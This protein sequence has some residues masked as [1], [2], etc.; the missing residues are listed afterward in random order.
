MWARAT[1]SASSRRSAT[2]SSTS[3]IAGPGQP[4]P[5]L[6]HP[7][8]PPS[9]PLRLT[10]DADPDPDPDQVQQPR[11][12][13]RHTPGVRGHAGG[14]VRRGGLALGDEQLLVG[15]E[16]GRGHGGRRR[17]MT[18][19]NSKIVNEWRAS[20]QSRVTSRFKSFAVC[21]LTPPWNIGQSSRRVWRRARAPNASVP[22][23]RRR[24]RGAG[25]A[26]RV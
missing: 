2:A 20:I 21:A 25:C 9:L 10:T 17:G 13:A 7:H 11:L 5:T 1:R 12:P 23:R 24:R 4:H 16:R 3:Y 22:A 8:T 19:R 14:Q 6:P 26:W 18:R 15:R